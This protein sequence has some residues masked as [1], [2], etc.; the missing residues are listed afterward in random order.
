VSLSSNKII[1]ASDKHLNG[2]QNSTEE[3][4]SL[5]DTCPRLTFCLVQGKRE[6]RERG[7]GKRYFTLV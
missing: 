3:T 2:P 6:E 5:S 1:T 7:R 4:F